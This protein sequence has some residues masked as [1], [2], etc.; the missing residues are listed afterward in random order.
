M[1]DFEYT[2]KMCEYETKLKEKQNVRYL[3][4]VLEKVFNYIVNQ[5]RENPEMTMFDI[6]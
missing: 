1:N 5:K 2:I 6:N 3:N 4:T